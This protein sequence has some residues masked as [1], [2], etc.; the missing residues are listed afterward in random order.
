M[1]YIYIYTHTY[2]YHIYIYIYTCMHI[3]IY[4]YINYSPNLI[5]CSS[6][7]PHEVFT[8]GIDLPIDNICIYIYIYLYTYVCMYVWN[9]TGKFSQGSFH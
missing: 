4:I 9:R 3:Y 2:V 8:D 5:R 7:K 6:G 1:L